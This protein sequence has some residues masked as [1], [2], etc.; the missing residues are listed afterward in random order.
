MQVIIKFFM[1]FLLKYLTS[2]SIE[3]IILI[4]LKKLVDSTESK[5][6]N[7]IYEAVFNKIK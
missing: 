4:G 3:K 7:E 1:T 6:D 5:I 2:E